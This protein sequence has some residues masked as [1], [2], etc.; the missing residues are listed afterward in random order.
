MTGRRLLAGL[1]LL[2]V[3][4]VAVRTLLASPRLEVEVEM[5]SEV[6]GRLQLFA[7][8]GRGFRQGLSDHAPV[9]GNGQVAAYLLTLRPR[10][11]VRALRLD[12]ADGP[13]RFAIHAVTVAFDGRRERFAAAELA[14]WKAA[15]L[16][17]EADGWRALGADPRLVLE[18]EWRPA[19]WTSRLVTRPAA[20]ELALAAAA[21][22]LLALALVPTLAGRT[23]WALAVAAPLLCFA[24]LN[25]QALGSWWV[26][27]DPCLLAAAGRGIGPHFWH[28]ETWR[29]LSGSVLMP[30]T[31]LS[32]G[33]DAALFGLAPAAFYA[34]QLLAFAL[35]LAGLAALLRAAGLAP[36]TSAL[37]ASLFAVSTPAC[38][39]AQ[40][41]MNRHYLEGTIFFLG[42]L[43]L[44][45]R[46]VRAR[47]SGP[48]VAGAVLYLLA[49]MAKEV[50]VPLAVLLPLVPAGDLRTRWRCAAP[51]AAVAALY[52]PW[53]LWMLGWANSLSGYAAKPGGRTMSD[54]PAVLGLGSGWQVAV[55][56][57]VAA[58]ALASV[59]RRSRRWLSF[60]AAA[61]AALALPLA[62][63]AGELAPRHFLLPALGAAVVVGAALERGRPMAR[64]ALGLALLVFA[65]HALAGSA[66][67]RRHGEAVERHRA[68]G[69]FVLASADG[70]VLLSRL[71]DPK[72]LAC[73]RELRTE[74]A[75]PGFCGDVCYCAGAFPETPFWHDA[76]GR[77]AAV[78]TPSEAPTC[79]VERELSAELRYDRA[80][81]RLAW[82][83]G[84]Y[85]DGRYELLLV[86]GGAVPEVSAPV[87]IAAAGEAPLA[88]AAPLRAVVAYRSPERWRT[89]SPV[90][91]LDPS[92]GQLHWER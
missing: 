81:G 76:G 74:A 18:R 62:P 44:Y 17:P 49:A 61:V 91:A 47:R 56:A 13:G 82:R 48:A 26:H 64:A 15:E 27:D 23:A 55:A 71:D 50:F 65:L 42:A 25:A 85:A 31:V 22:A 79:A 80:R 92:S 36:W 35:L 45:A 5:A 88:L 12:P 2:A 1:L 86:T 51:F 32:L 77:I 53:R 67:W 21:A 68:E 54:V 40:Q 33:T 78:A 11:A 46:A 83:L 57:I 59:L 87:P 39:V 34:H 20:R 60:G 73:V 28:P 89:Y 43:A 8:D 90:L 63:V 69:A 52:V 37:A 10:G 14:A 72:Y 19:P 70:G 3:W 7:D 38:A 16:R 30:W 9:V 24:A 29:A 75:G 58:L 66:F 4:V 6:T 41:L 84:P